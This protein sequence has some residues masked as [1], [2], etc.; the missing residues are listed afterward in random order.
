M[1][2]TMRRNLKSLSWIL[3][4]TVASFVIA[5]FAVWGRGGDA[6]GVAATWMARVNGEPVSAATFQQAYFNMD[7]YYRQ[8]Y[9]EGYDPQSLGVAR[10]ALEQLIRERL[11]LDEARRLGLRTTPREISSAIT[12][13]PN[14]QVDGR[15]MG[16]GEYQKL[17]EA[18]GIEVASYEA[19][20]GEALMADKYRRLVTDSITV[21]FDEV[22]EDYRARN[23]RVKADYIL[24]QPEDLNV[25]V[26]AE[27][28]DLRRFYESRP[29][30]YRSPERRRSV[31]VLVNAERLAG[32]EPVSDEEARSYYET[33]LE[34]LYSTPPQVRAS[35]ILL[36]VDA[37]ATEEQI[38]A[39]ETRA[40][41][42]VQRLASGGDFAELARTYSEDTS[43]TLG[44][45]L[46]FFGRGRMRPEF[47]EAAF[48]MGTGETSGLIR[49]DVGFH[50]IHLTDRREPTTR[51]FSEMRDSIVRQLGFSRSQGS[52]ARAV[53]ALRAAVEADPSA[54]ESTTA[55]LGLTIEDAGAAPADGSL[56]GLGEYPQLL[57]AL[58]RTDQG[59]VSAP[60]P[61]P[62]GTAFLKVRE[63][64]AP[65]RLPFEDARSQVELD[66]GRERAIEEGRRRVEELVASGGELASLA[67]SLGVEVAST[68]AFTRQSR[69]HPFGIEARDLAFGSEE[70]QVVGPVGVDDGLLVFAVAEYEA[71]DA[72]QFETIKQNL[73]RSLMEQRRSQFFATV[74]NQLRARS[75]IQINQARLDLLEGRGT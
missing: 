42:I 50:L 13:D 40:R 57:Q 8:I 11:I 36:K 23:E 60:V 17:L 67:E 27:E 74:V 14:F 5:L 62:E 30:G 56:Q 44:G 21:S 54:F 64:L 58:F 35:Q 31:Y 48:A 4:L 46:G 63:I 6:A 73:R 7:R 19:N 33:N 70:G 24:L 75:E 29:E 12:Q 2:R 32:I 72:E 25:D 65:E 9:R 69:P 41:E 51:P 66:Y 49:T 52:V 39:V 1:L 38:A 26:A 59:E 43:A 47:D 22:L 71:L 10:L 45:D 15:F 3:W 55:E 61:L 16:A 18:R 34:R 20:V 68:Q 53:A 28:A 37:S